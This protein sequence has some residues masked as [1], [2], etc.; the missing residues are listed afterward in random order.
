MGQPTG[1]ETPRQLKLA[2]SR[3]VNRTVDKPD[4][5]DKNVTDYKAD[6][7]TLRNIALHINGK[8]KIMP[9]FAATTE[10]IS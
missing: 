8:T 6:E 7:M 9:G 10:R 3:N 5:L 2:L 1:V 4:K